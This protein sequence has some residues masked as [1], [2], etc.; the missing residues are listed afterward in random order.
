MIKKLNLKFYR[1]GYGA[2]Q[3]D[4][5]IIQ[6]VTHIAETVNDCISAIES[7]ESRLEKLEKSVDHIGEPTKTMEANEHK[8]N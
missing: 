8:T 4:L 7:L 2:S 1:G 6:V 3:L 5:Q